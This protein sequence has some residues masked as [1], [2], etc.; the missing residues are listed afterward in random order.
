MKPYVI[1][2]ARQFGSMGRLIGKRL[3][4]E[5]NIGYYDRELIE[6]AADIMKKPVGDISNYDEKAT[7]KFTKMLYPMGVS[8]SLME[9]KVFDLQKTI[10]QE[11]ALKESCVI[12][13]RCADYIL[14]NHKNSIHIFIYAPYEQR[15]NNCIHELNLF[16]DEAIKMIDSVD[17]ARQMYHKY[18]TNEELYGIDGKHLLVDSS[19]LGIDGTMKMLKSVVVEKFQLNDKA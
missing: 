19:L 2:I 13:G 3:A 18:H 17:K 5:L 10:I 11:I 16:Q 1:T 8:T 4:E 6:Q 14:R 9:E 7:G 15:L 12:V